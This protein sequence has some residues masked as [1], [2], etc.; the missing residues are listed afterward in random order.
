MRDIQVRYMR[1][2]AALH[3]GPAGNARSALHVGI[4]AV[5]H[6][7]LHGLAARAVDETSDMAM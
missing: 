5:K 7:G 3:G 6:A 1:C 4:F 2:L